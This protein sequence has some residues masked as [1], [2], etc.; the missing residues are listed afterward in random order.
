MCDYIA[1]RGLRAQMVHEPV[2]ENV[3]GKS[4]NKFVFYGVTRCGQM[5][6]VRDLA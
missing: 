1:L 4:M 3:Y 5:L 6:C 2:R